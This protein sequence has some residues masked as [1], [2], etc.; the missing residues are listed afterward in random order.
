MDFTRKACWVKYGHHTPDPKESNY[1]GVVSRDSIRIDLNYSALNDLD[2]TDA[3]IQNAYLQVPS[4]D[5]NY[6]ICGKEFG[7]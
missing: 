4:S 1:D 3:D 2:V 7:L 5:K 6:V